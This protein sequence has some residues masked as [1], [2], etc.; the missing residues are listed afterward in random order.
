M[1]VFLDDP[2][3]KEFFDLACVQLQNVQP[4]LRGGLAD[5]LDHPYFSHPVVGILEF[6]SAITLKTT[7]EK[8]QFFRLVHHHFLIICK[9]LIQFKF[10]RSLW[11]QLATL[12]ETMVATQLADLLLSRLV[13]LEPSA[14]TQLVPWLL[15]I[16]QDQSSSGKTLLGHIDIKT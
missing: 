9:N 1:F 16:K 15:A 2:S 14:Q 6:L 13:L 7:S 3:G 4:K 5:L 11:A 12:P 10:C 8:E